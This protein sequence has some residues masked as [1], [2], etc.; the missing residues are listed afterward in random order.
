[1]EFV[2]VLCGSALITEYPNGFYCKSCTRF[3]AVKEREPKKTEDQIWPDVILDEDV[4]RAV[5]LWL[6]TGNEVTEAPSYLGFLDSNNALVAEY[7]PVSVNSS[8]V[9]W[10]NTMCEDVFGDRDEDIY[11][12]LTKEEPEK[13][14][15]DVVRGL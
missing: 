3:V 12:S 11:S 6:S 1:M 15:L 2:C 4:N 10:V 5:E 7:E 13:S 14:F 8:V 9:R